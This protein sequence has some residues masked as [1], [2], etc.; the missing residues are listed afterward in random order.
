MASHPTDSDCI[1]CAIIAGDIP[2]RIVGETDDAV[3]FLDVNPLAPG[4][5]LVVP[6]G[7]Y[8]TVATT[9]NEQ[10]TGVFDLLGRLTPDVEMAVDA[11]ASNLGINNGPASGQEV[12]HL[13][14][15]IIPRFVDDGGRPIHAVGGDAPD[16][17]EDEFDD[18]AD[19]IVSG[20]QRD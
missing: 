5:T 18:I 2:A 9:P 6:R 14:A 11:D 19:R 7:H 8:E 17:S 20:T 12:P 13:H 1:F 10:L 4:H 16:L 3:A 15:H